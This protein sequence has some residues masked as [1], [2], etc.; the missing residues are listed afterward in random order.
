[1]PSLNKLLTLN[2]T[3]STDAEIYRAYNVSKKARPLN[4][5]QRL[6][7]QIPV[8]IASQTK[9]KPGQFIKFDLYVL[10]N[11]ENQ[12]DPPLN[13]LR[14]KIKELESMDN[15]PKKCP[16]GN[17][18]CRN[19]RRNVDGYKSQLVRIKQDGQKTHYK[20][21]TTNEIK[22][23][24]GSSEFCNILN[25]MA[26]MSHNKLKIRF[27]NKSIKSITR[28]SSQKKKL[29]TNDEETGPIFTLRC[30]CKVYTD[31]KAKNIRDD[32][33]RNIVRGL[34][35]WDWK[36]NQNLGQRLASDRQVMYRG[37]F[38]II[39]YQAGHLEPVGTHMIRIGQ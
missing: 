23:W 9:K 16:P 5:I 30:V 24:L 3:S 14:K 17:T 11:T 8:D 31:S 15:W 4:P 26:G 32:T 38:D 2:P 37:E 20:V 39:N 1:M 21:L 18:L 33:V 27:T 13:Q 7:K 34:N 6:R 36:L 28:L 10:Y 19:Y 25:E 12:K 35:T 22:Q 29:L